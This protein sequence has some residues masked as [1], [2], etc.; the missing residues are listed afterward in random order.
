[1]KKLINAPESVLSDA[2]AGIA[3]AHPGLHVDTQARIITRAG[4]PSVGQA[5]P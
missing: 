4:G 2:L 1:M 5:S 3:A